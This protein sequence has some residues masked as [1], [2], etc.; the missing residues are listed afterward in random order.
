MLAHLEELALEVGLRGGPDDDDVVLEEEVVGKSRSS[1]T[2]P[3][4]RATFLWCRRSKYSGMV[5]SPAQIVCDTLGAEFER[6][7][8]KH[9]QQIIIIRTC[10][11]HL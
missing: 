11:R 2:M 8:Y 7:T 5:A 4:V 9:R 6:S 1:L 10:F 3:W